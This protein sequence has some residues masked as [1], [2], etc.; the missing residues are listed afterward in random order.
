MKVKVTYTMDYYSVPD[1][2]SSILDRCKDNF[3]R[4]SR[5]RLDPH[6]MENLMLEINEIRDSMSLIDSQLEDSISMM[7]GYYEAQTNNLES[8]LDLKEEIN[9]EG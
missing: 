2:V 8:L 3:Q 6:N 9:E 4:F 1:L 5:M 7:S